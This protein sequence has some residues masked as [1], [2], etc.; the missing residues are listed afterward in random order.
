M[1]TTWMVNTTT[2]TAS[3]TGTSGSLRYCVSSAANGDTVD[4]ESGTFLLSSTLGVLAVSHS[5]TIVGTGL[6]NTLISGNGAVQVFNVASG[7]TASISSLT[8][9]NG[10]A[11]SAAA[12]P[13]AGID[14]NGT[15]TL[16]NDAISGNTDLGTAT[17]VSYSAYGG[18]VFNAAGATMTVTNSTIS[19]SYHPSQQNT[20]TGRLTEAMLDQVFTRARD[21]LNVKV[22]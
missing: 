9:E 8:V 6:A 22:L 19:G 11:T 3:G 5:I 7:V 17:S 16:A 10:Y 4:V 20:F 21:R 12:V 18:G 14:N 1:P 13:G 2:D 15:L